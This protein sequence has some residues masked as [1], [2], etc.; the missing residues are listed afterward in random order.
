MTRKITTDRADQPNR[1]VAKEI[2]F[3][4]R[5]VHSLEQ[6]G[7]QI[8]RDMAQRFQHVW[9]T[10]QSMTKSN[11]QLSELCQHVSATTKHMEQ[12]MIDFVRKHQV[13]PASTYQNRHEFSTAMAY[14]ES[15]EAFLDAHA[16]RLQ[17]NTQ[18]CDCAS[19]KAARHGDAIADAQL[20]VLGARCDIFVYKD[21]Y[22][23]EPADVLQIGKNT[24]PS[25][26]LFGSRIGKN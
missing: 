22:G 8:D 16:Q 15:R 19:R 1:N 6:K 18:E 14:T 4:R 13:L 23:L 7:V 11:L 3:L 2:E 9:L 12:H 17:L 20:Y 24:T 10:C 5:R 26:L 21:L 25:P